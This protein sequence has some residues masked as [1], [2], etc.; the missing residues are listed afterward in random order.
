MIFFMCYM[1][2]FFGIFFAG[3]IGL[4]PYEMQ[5]MIPMWLRFPFFMI[6]IIIA[7]VGLS[8]VHI[9]AKKTGAEH[10][11]ESGRPGTILWFYV[12]RDG[13]VK[14]TPSM[15]E[16]EGQLYSRELDAQI[17]DLKSYR[18]FDH[19]I[20]F[21]PEGIGHAVDLDMVLYATLL[22]T[23]YG[24]SNIEEAREKG[25]GKDKIVA[26][27]KIKKPDSNIPITGGIT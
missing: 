22:R 9:R 27:E 6:G 4:F 3:F 21:V 1:L 19:S 7:M 14:I 23:K 2:V 26:T 5:Y 11:L 13:T 24:F 20:R 17:H 18:L 12:F 16:I 25:F 10:L 15:R 8:M